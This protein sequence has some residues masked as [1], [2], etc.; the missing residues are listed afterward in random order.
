MR[1][2][3]FTFDRHLLGIAETEENIPGRTVAPRVIVRRTDGQELFLTAEFEV[4][5]MTFPIGVTPV[6]DP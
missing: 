6:F 1:N 4:R 3:A 2:R 5:L